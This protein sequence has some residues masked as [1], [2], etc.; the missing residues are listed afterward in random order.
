MTYFKSSPK[1][2]AFKVSG[3]L[4][5]AAPLYGGHE[6]CVSSDFKMTRSFPP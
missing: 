5:G 4:S 6:N 3:A 1:C 2:F